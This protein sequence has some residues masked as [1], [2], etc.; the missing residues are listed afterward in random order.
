MNTRRIFIRRCHFEGIAGLIN[1]VR[2]LHLDNLNAKRSMYIQAVLHAVSDLSAR[3][4]Y[5]A[6]SPHS[7]DNND[8]DI[9][10]QSIVSAMLKEKQLPADQLRSRFHSSGWQVDKLVRTRPVN[11]IIIAGYL[12]DM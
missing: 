6:Q 11:A 12:A 9:L 8:N 10:P 5:I 4:V 2:E 3:I 1:L 7:Y